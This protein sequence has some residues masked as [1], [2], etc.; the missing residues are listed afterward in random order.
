MFEPFYTT[1][2]PG[3]GTGLGL[4]TVYGIVAQSGGCIYVQ[5]E[6]GRGTTFTV[7]LPRVD[8][9]GDP[10]PAHATVAETEQI[11]RPSWSSIQTRPFSLS[12]HGYYERRGYK[13]LPCTMPERQPPTLADPSVRVDALADRPALSGSL[14]GGQVA[15]SA[16][17]RR[18][19]LPV[20]FMSAQTRD[21]IRGR[22][23][24][25][26][27]RRPAGEALHGGGVD[28]KSANVPY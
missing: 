19:E 3:Q 14:Q 18:P 5:S 20:L 1:K 13:V 26:D 15:R 9:P 25:A 17:K 7:Y 11:A 22:S 28:S 2:P 24:A 23:R 21:T 16:A 4:A 10:E 6:P 27:E 8:P 12:R